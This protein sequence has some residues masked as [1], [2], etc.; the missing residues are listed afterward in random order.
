M[1]APADR[2]GERGRVLAVIA[3]QVRFRFGVTLE[4]FADRTIALAGAA[5]RSPEEFIPRLHLDDLYLA[6]ACA[7]GDDGA[8]KE[9]QRAH[10][11][12]I[13]DFAQRFLPDAAARDLAD[14]VIADLWQRGKIAR[15]EGRSTLRTWLGTVVAH[16]A[17]N[18][19]R[20]RRTFVPIDAD[21]GEGQAARLRGTVVADPAR[22]ESERALA[23]IV[24]ASVAALPAEDKLLLQLYYEQE[25]TLEAMQVALRTSKAT[26]S[27]RLTAIRGRLRAAVDERARR[28]VGTSAAALREDASL[29]H[30]ELDLSELFRAGND[31]ESDSRRAV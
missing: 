20:T 1:P 26:L 24:A 23:A 15:Y 27:R 22:L 5:P 29:E 19:G 18:A 31:M 2:A 3:A 4:Q 28:D 16:A 7:A 30:L 12:F 21:A 11:A 10:F 25:L 9:C 17:I 14:Q 13:R 6:A 8:W